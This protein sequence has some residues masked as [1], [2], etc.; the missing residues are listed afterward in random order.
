MIPGGKQTLRQTPGIRRSTMKTVR[1]AQIENQHKIS[2]LANLSPKCSA[3]TK[4]RHRVTMTTYGGSGEGEIRTPGPL[5][6][7]GFQDQC[8]RPLCHLSEA[9]FAGPCDCFEIRRNVNDTRSRISACLPSWKSLRNR[10]VIFRFLHMPRA[11]RPGRSKGECIISE[12][13][14]NLTTHRNGI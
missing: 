10:I 9:L 14:L 7:A 11:S 8:I 13:D 1:T 5:R 3:Q 12:S 2:T 6:D 4:G